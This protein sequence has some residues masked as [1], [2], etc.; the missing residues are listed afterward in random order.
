MDLGERI[1]MLRSAK[2]WSSG[3]LAEE[4]DVSRAYLWQL[5]TGGKDNPSFDVLE[6]LANALGVSVSEFSDSRAASSGQSPMPP[7]LLEFVRNRGRDLGITKQDI[8]V[9]K[10]VHFR[11]VQPDKPEDWELLYLFLQKWARK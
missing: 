9:M 1:K 4:A 5:E 11:G 10:G 6:K 7:A 3:Q 8:E 2:G